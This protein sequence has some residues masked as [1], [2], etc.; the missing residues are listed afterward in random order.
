MLYQIICL[1][2]SSFSSVSS[3]FISSSNNHAQGTKKI[4]LRTLTA[5]KTWVNVCLFFTK[6]WFNLMMPVVV[7]RTH[8]FCKILFFPIFDLFDTICCWVASCL[9]CGRSMDVF[10][11]IVK[12]K[13][14]VWDSNR[15]DDTVIL[16]FDRHVYVCSRSI[17]YYIKIL[18]KILMQFH[19][20]FWKDSRSIPVTW[21]R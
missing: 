2:V 17:I 9:R 6:C 11:M 12:K 21:D 19:W 3:K 14:I 10:N 13:S 16:E 20:T 15:V 8:L 4:N 7:E 1:F 18:L 5:V